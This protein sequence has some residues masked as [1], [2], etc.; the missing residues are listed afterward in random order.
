MCVNVHREANHNTSIRANQN[1]RNSPKTTDRTRERRNFANST[2]DE[3]DTTLIVDDITKHIRMAKTKNLTMADTSVRELTEMLPVILS[4]HP[5][6]MKI[7]IHTG[8]FDILQRKTGSEILNIYFSILLEKV[9][10]FQQH[11]FITLGKGIGSFSRLLG[12]NTWLTSACLNHGISYRVP[13]TPTLSTEF[14]KDISLNSKAHYRQLIRTYGTHYIHQVNLGGQVTVTTAISTCQAQNSGHSTQEVESCLSMG[15]KKNIGLGVNANFHKCATVLDSHSSKSSSGS[16]IFSQYS[17]VTGGSSWTMDMSPNSDNVEGFRNWKSS[18]KDHPD[19]IYYSLK[20]LHQLIPDPVAR[21][22]VKKAV[23]EYLIENAI[24]ET[25]ELPCGDPNSKKDSFCCFKSVSQGHLVVT[26]VRAWDLYGDAEW[27]QG[28]TDAYAVVTYGSKIKHTDMITSQ[29]PVWNAL[30]EMGT[31]QK[32]EELTVIVMDQDT[33]DSNDNLG[34]CTKT[35]HQG[36][37][38]YNCSLT[39]GTVE[40]RYT[41]TCEPYLIGDQCETYKPSENI[42]YNYFNITEFEPFQPNSKSVTL[43][44]DLPTQSSALAFLSFIYMF[45]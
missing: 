34:S 14:L 25:R 19:I 17:R 26:V 32:D 31:F 39:T 5:S 16:E 18:L 30:L 15:F 37:H 1:P 6:N 4:T 40:F 28:E 41:L 29:N 42:V 2:F 35:I 13:N 3:P 20:P 27:I 38:E 44:S 23:Q 12:L 24:M 8:T 21:Q 10:N 36:T 22:G 11:V 9:N 7:I 43:F 33:L 45:L